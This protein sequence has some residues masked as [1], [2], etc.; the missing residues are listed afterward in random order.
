MNTELAPTALNLGKIAR[1]IQQEYPAAESF[2]ISA[3][4][5]TRTYMISGLTNEGY[6][7]P[8]PKS[9]AVGDPGSVDWETLDALIDQSLDFDDYV[10]Q[11]L[12]VHSTSLWG[13]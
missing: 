6:Y 4:P 9:L 8:H 7:H 1:H 12:E 13:E 5:D 2:D 3:R 11:D 10:G